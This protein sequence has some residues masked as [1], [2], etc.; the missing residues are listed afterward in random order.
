MALCT[1]CGDAIKDLC[2]I[3]SKPDCLGI[4]RPGQRNGNRCTGT[5]ETECHP[6]PVEEERLEEIVE[7]QLE[8]MYHSKEALPINPRLLLSLIKEVRELRRK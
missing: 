7:Y 6:R 3:C 1:K 2:K 4:G 8:C 5:I